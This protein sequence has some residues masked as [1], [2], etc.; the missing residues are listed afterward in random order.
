MTERTEHPRLRTVARLV[1]TAQAR[2]KVAEALY[3]VL[4]DGMQPGPCD[5]P[6]AA[7][8]EWLRGA[9]AIPLQEATDSALETLVWQISQALEHAPNGLLDRLERSRRWQELG[10]E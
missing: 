10:W 9:M 8:R 6:E 2:D 4:L 1:A 5:L 7:D 3:E